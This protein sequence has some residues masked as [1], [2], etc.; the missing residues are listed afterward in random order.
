[1]QLVSHITTSD[2]LG[3]CLENGLQ[4]NPTRGQTS[5]WRAREQATDE[6]RPG[7]VKSLGISRLNSVYAHPDLAIVEPI[8]GLLTNQKSTKQE[9]LASIAIE[10]DPSSVIVCDAFLFSDAYQP[11]KYWES[12]ISLAEYYH[13]YV[14]NI[15]A[16]GVSIT[17]HSSAPVYGS[18]PYKYFQPEV[19]IPG[20]VGPER[21]TL[22]MESEFPLDE[23]VQ[24]NS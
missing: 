11:A 23:F 19:L 2:R 1:M 15:S 5:Q 22:H 16:Y 20:P 9:R 6:A 21:L 17:R 3:G 13:F 12:A 7:F 18:A 24:W 4:P 14:P 8:M 10:V